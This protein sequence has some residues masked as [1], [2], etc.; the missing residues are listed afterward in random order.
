MVAERAE[1]APSAFIAGGGFSALKASCKAIEV[2]KRQW[3]EDPAEDIYVDICFSYLH[4]Y[5]G[6]TFGEKN[7]FEPE[8]LLT[9]PPLLENS[10]S[11]V[12]DEKSD[13]TEDASKTCF[14]VEN[15]AAQINATN[16]LE[17][18]QK[19]KESGPHEAVC[20][21][22]V[23]K[24]ALK[25]T[26]KP[27]NHVTT[28]G[29]SGLPRALCGDVNGSHGQKQAHRNDE[30]LPF[31]KDARFSE[32]KKQVSLTQTYNV[33]DARGS[34]AKDPEQPDIQHK[35]VFEAEN[36]QKIQTRRGIA[37]EKV[38]SLKPKLK[39][40]ATGAMKQLS[41]TYS[42][43]S[44]ASGAALKSESGVSPEDKQ[45]SSKS[46][47]SETMNSRNSTVSGNEG[48][49][50]AANEDEI[51]PYVV[52]KGSTDDDAAFTSLGGIDAGLDSDT[53]SLHSGAMFPANS[54][55][56]G[57]AAG[58]PSESRGEERDDIV[59]K[60]VRSIQNIFQKK[61]SIKHAMQLLRKASLAA[62][63]P[64]AKKQGETK[65]GEPQRIA[66]EKV[67][68]SVG[69]NHDVAGSGGDKKVV[70]ETTGKRSG[71]AV[72]L[73][74][75]MSITKVANFVRKMSLARKQSTHDTGAGT[76]ATELEGVGT[77]GE[78]PAAVKAHEEN[79]AINESRPDTLGRRFS[80]Q[81]FG[82][83][84]A[85]IG[86]AGILAGSPKAAHRLSHR[87]N[88]SKTAEKMTS[89]NAGD[90]VIGIESSE[91]DE[92]MPSAPSKSADAEEGAAELESATGA[93]PNPRVNRRFSIQQ[94]VQ[95][96]KRLGSES[97]R[98]SVPTPQ[99]DNNPTDTQTGNAE[100]NIER[101]VQRTT[102][103]QRLFSVTK[104]DEMPDETNEM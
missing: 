2:G 9:T 77:E 68:T 4:G 49:E 43:N 74:R 30:I 92:I 41:R 95:T 32:Q 60:K 39:A 6:P 38:D 55:E 83:V 64:D 44:T 59:D 40:S 12:N 104:S 48:L 67:N 99:T 96:V 101:Q 45:K 5:N 70:K 86:S 97:K 82:N 69:Q 20:M 98:G 79:E 103:L 57:D 33:V 87:E 52:E 7:L 36:G 81:Q 1:G 14:P 19:E 31:E 3:G 88:D 18:I 47:D 24:N 35:N 91:S 93:G 63:K 11:R 13:G 17:E 8:N 28:T 34:I 54:E 84:A 26:P 46:R 15:H 58:G 94:L 85:R 102:I 73:Q 71:R 53:S 100:R 23:D 75:T 50:E 56:S 61:L 90:R 27:S 37:T 51:Q 29:V 66:E 78:A 25:Q 10:T 62:E 42:R 76:A 80:I 89:N 16:S 65:K 72:E 22:N 21:M